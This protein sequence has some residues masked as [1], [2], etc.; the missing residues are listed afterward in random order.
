MTK[1][2]NFNYPPLTAMICHK[3]A[4]EVICSIKKSIEQGAEAF[5]ILTEAL[6]SEDKN[7]MRIKE[8]LDAMDGR[9]SYL[10]NYV[11]NNSQPYLTDDELAEQLLGMAKLG[12][13]LI[14][15]RTDMFC[16]SKDEITLDIEAVNKQK[17]LI[18]RLHD[19]GAEVLMSTHIFEY[20]S[21]QNIL[22][23][24]SLQKERGVDICKIVTTVDTKQ[25]LD[26]AFKTNLLLKERLG[27]P[28]LFLCNGSQCRNHRLLSPVFGS[29]ISLCL[30]NSKTEGPQPTIEEAK[31]I[32]EKFLKMGE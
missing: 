16:R 26:D 21:P 6:E 19:L 14:D 32:R 18:T 1:F 30:E 28:F 23:I 2:L 13:N 12:A 8:I 9:P 4:S 22:E 27:L 20:R 31:T 25:E 5:C 15:V 7:V 3:T 17:Q 29:C 10:T 11:R 24:A